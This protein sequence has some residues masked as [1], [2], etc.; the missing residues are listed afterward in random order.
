MLHETLIL[1]EGKE[2][3]ESTRTKKFLPMFILMFDREIET[4]KLKHYGKI[5]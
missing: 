4:N 5:N 3:L 1:E 2:N